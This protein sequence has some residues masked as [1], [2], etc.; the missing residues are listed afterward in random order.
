MI[1]NFALLFSMILFA[2]VVTAQEHSN[3]AASDKYFIVQYTPGSAFNK[4]KPIN[5]QE[6]YKE[7]SS[8]LSDLRKANHIDIGGRYNNTLMLL[9]RAKSEDEAQS[10]VQDDPAVKNKLFQVEL[11]PFTPFFNGC[12]R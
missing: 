6:H 1:K 11:F 4:S 2:S 3:P 12:V 9:L 8:H 7:H 10:L 5:E